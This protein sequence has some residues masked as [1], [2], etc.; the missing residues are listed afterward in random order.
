MDVENREQT[1]PWPASL[2]ALIAAPEHH[3]LLF[4]NERVRVLSTSIPAG[5]KTAIHTH[6]WPSVLHVL[7]WGHFVRYDDEG[8]VLVD[9]RTVEAFEDPPEVIWSPPLPPHS[10]ENVSQTDLTVF[11]VEL[12]DD[13]QAV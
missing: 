6:C 10:L 4:E 5:E 8:T 9:S 11:A 7:S 13:S 2:D 3:K 1:W 12:K